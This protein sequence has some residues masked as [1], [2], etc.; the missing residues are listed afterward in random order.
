[1]H[2]NVANLYTYRN[3]LWYG[4]LIQHPNTDLELEDWWNTSLAGLPKA[5]RRP[6]AAVPIYTAWIIWKQWQSELKS[7]YAEFTTNNLF[8]EIH[9]CD[10][11]LQCNKT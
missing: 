2:L 7:T 3:S 9:T 5:L 8:K 4:G 1:M 11:R 6:K 10:K